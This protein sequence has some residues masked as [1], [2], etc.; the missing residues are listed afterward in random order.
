MGGKRRDI[1]QIT[2]GPWYN[3]HGLIRYGG[4]MIIRFSRKF[5]DDLSVAY[6]IEFERREDS[7]DCSFSLKI[8][9]ED[10]FNPAVNIPIE[11]NDIPDLTLPK[12]EVA[13]REYINVFPLEISNRKSFD[14]FFSTTDPYILNI[15]SI[16]GISAAFGHYFTP[17]TGKPLEDSK[18]VS[19]CIEKNVLGNVLPDWAR[20]GR[21]ILFI[22]TTYSQKH[23]NDFRCLYND[24]LVGKM[25]Y[26]IYEDNLNLTFW[27]DTESFNPYYISTGSVN[28][29]YR[30]L[31]RK[32]GVF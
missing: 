30:D 25:E 24:G 18:Y 19:T 22:N 13:A 29:V 10:P 1:R 17:Y 12:V 7:D 2:F 9:Q 23:E 15:V 11:N 6:S 16:I 20:F 3:S 32:I 8:C 14:S 28:T 21:R 26:G 5:R 31:C 4:N 27:I